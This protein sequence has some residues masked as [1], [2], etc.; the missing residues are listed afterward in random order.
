MI[1]LNMARKPT[2]GGG[3]SRGI[4]GH[5]RQ[6]AGPTPPKGPLTAAALSGTVHSLHG[7]C[8]VIRSCITV[9]ALLD[10]KQINSKLDR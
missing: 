8:V 3:P 7:Q 5:E 2:T 1:C 4:F 10:G 6:M 9:C